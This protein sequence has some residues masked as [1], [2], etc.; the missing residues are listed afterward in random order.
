MNLPE[1]LT[2]VISIEKYQRSKSPA[3]IITDYIAERILDL[4]FTSN[5]NA[6]IGIKDLSVPGLSDHDAIIADID[7]NPIINIQ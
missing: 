4:F 7:I 6:L 1:I 3:S 2:Q 5:P